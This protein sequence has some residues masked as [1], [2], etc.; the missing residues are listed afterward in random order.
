[1]L[2][3][4]TYAPD[5]ELT[6]NDPQKTIHTLIVSND[7]KGIKKLLQTNDL[8]NA[9]GYFKYENDKYWETP[10][11]TA[12]LRVE[13]EKDKITMVK[14]LLK[15]NADPNSLNYEDVTP[16]EWAAET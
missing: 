9:K 10:L 3:E 4:Y 12:I 2:I 8:A 1:M 16:L 7:Q 14:L 5:A 13:N 6:T 11:H 15:N